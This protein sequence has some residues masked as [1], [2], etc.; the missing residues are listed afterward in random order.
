MNHCTTLFI[1]LDVHKEFIA[2]AYVT[3]DCGM[4]ITYLDPIGTRQCDID[5][6]KQRAYLG[7]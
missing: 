6:S 7:L 2:I 4:D 1:G 3:D 5:H